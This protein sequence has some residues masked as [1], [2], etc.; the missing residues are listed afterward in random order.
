LGIGPEHDY[1]QQYHSANRT[2][3]GVV[4]QQ[5]DAREELQHASPRIQQWRRRSHVQSNFTLPDGQDHAQRRKY[6]T[7]PQYQYGS[8]LKHIAT[9]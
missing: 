9:H 7:W 4:H 8:Y 1:G 5:S 6:P 2:E 3:T